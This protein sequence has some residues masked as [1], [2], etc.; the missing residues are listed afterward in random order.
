MLSRLPL[1]VLLTLPYILLLLVLATA[2]GWLSYRAANEAVG[3]MASRLSNAIG[4][5]IEEVTT[6]Y[7]ANWQYTLAAAAGWNGPE[8]QV[9]LAS[10][11][12]ELW[13]A[14]SLSQVPGSYVY[15]ASPD[16]RFVGVQ[17]RAS[18]PA[19]L[20]L[21]DSPGQAPRRLFDAAHP[22]DRALPVG[23]EPQAYDATQRPWYRAA[24]GRPGD[25]WSPVYL[26]FS[27][28][29]PMTTLA[30]ARRDAAGQLL[31]VYGADVPLAQ[32]E[33][34]LQRLDIAQRGIAYLVTRDGRLIAST[35][36]APATSAARRDLA[37]ATDSASADL[38][39]SFRALAPQL[40][41]GGDNARRA[42]SYDTPS[43]RMLV[44]AASLAGRAGVDWWVV[45]ALRE[46]ALTAG[47]TR[48]AYS[49]VLLAVLAAA[50][51]LLLGTAVLEGLVRD[52]RKLTRAAEQLSTDVSPTPLLIARR[53]DLGRLGQ[54]FNRM[55]MRLE[56]SAQT[57]R[58][59][60]ESLSATVTELGAQ[61]AA[62]DAAE[63]RLRHMADSLTEA[64]VVVDRQWK[65]TYVNALTEPYARQS[66]E[67]MLGRDLWAVFARAA[68]TTVQ[69]QL[70]ASVASGKPSTLEVQAPD[71][72]AW[73]EL[74]V[75]PSNTGAAV[76]FS[77]VTERVAI[78]Q[79]QAERAAQ[80]HRLAGALL[81]S[82]ADERRSIAR[83]LH[84][85]LGQQ[86]AAVR[87]NLEVLGDECAG[88]PAASARLADALDT[89]QQVIV[90]V[91][92]RALD[93]HPS[94]LDDLGLGAALLWLCD[95]QSRRL[96]IAVELHGDD[97]MCGLPQ[98]VEL[99]CFR[100]AQEAINNAAKHSGA[101]RIDVSLELTD[102]HIRLGITDNGRGFNLRPSNT[103][104]GERSLGLVSM[105]ERAEQFG[106]HFE[107]QSNALHGTTVKA[108]IPVSFDEQDQS[109]FGR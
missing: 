28:Q 13:A 70:M 4:E 20:K 102:G 62:R 88:R 40:A 104:T 105:R 107:V 90:K 41:K 64:L 2:V 74:R 31:G 75:F 39:A 42:V 54:A 52:I 24:M 38:A 89:L 25:V 82:Q 71:G 108:S 23:Q 37:A 15:F 101:Q 27:T 53:D 50:G 45:V 55:A 67:Q 46:D 9:D 10:T 12:R 66:V 44:S 69:S 72:Q 17:R 29:A 34:F 57:V 19:L 18:G 21:R 8:R 49:T 32:L 11:E 93:L 109:T 22:G 84:D 78:R 63:G 7:L 99:A 96:G 33:G 48:N 91:R 76:F 6:A 51:V 68:G 103:D 59:Q 73:F 81:T 80:M 94:V 106:G 77:D 5:R 35:V 98:D 56:S 92:S 1:R 86:L 85:E 14:G 26:D 95:R 65:I 47:I 30:R 3:D 58:R 61:I 87:I 100:I 97:H 43:G 36:A 60:N 83:E 79:A 16:G